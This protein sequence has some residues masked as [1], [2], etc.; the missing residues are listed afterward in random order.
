MHQILSYP[1]CEHY[2]QLII[3]KIRMNSWP[4]Y[5]CYWKRLNR[6]TVHKGKGGVPQQ[7]VKKF[8]GLHCTLP[9]HVRKHQPRR[10]AADG[11]IHDIT[12]N[13]KIEKREP[14]HQPE[15]PR[16]CPCFVHFFFYVFSF[17]R[18]SAA[19]KFHRIACHLK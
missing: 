18:Q 2:V 11:H 1:M 15:T 12:D 13:N 14:P 8:F 5:A 7:I 16:V 6:T 3:R 17:K 19:D 4:Y 10:A 9:T